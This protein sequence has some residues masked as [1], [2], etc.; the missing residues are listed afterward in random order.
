MVFSTALLVK[1]RALR[2]VLTIGNSDIAAKET[3][4]LKSK[5]APANPV[6]CIK[7]LLLMYRAIELFTKSI[8]IG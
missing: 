3:V 7:A 1:F 6:F 2:G 8:E 4:L 5:P